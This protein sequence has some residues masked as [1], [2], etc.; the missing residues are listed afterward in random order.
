MNTLILF[1]TKNGTTRKCAEMLKEKINKEVDLLE[2]N[3]KSKI[4]L[5]DYDQVILGGSIYIGKIQKSLRKFMEDNKAILLKKSLGLFVC[6]M[7]E[8]LELKNEI[9]ANFPKELI[10]H[11]TQVY[12]LAWS[13]DFDKMNFLEKLIAKKVAKV[14]ETTVSINEI[15]IE[16][17]A[18]LFIK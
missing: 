10:K 8:G 3:K 1:S 9:D 11:A 5:N 13:F 12:C 17:L 18:S 2:L 16:E 6:A 7:G 4:D 14:N 15:Q